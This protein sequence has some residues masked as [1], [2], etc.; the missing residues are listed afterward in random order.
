ME[1]QANFAN[2]PRIRINE[3]SKF[4]TRIDNYRR[5]NVYN[6]TAMKCARSGAESGNGSFRARTDELTSFRYISI[7]GGANVY[8]L[9]EIA[10]RF[11][12]Y[13]SADSSKEKISKIYKRNKAIRSKENCTL[14]YLFH[15]NAPGVRWG[16]KLP[17]T[18]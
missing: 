8:F 14:L 6:R 17:F 7:F 9:I 18:G 13:V 3:I 12:L 15:L 4:P 1:A 11:D 16:F 2:E 10:I 5:K